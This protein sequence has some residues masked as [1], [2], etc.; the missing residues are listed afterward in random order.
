MFAVDKKRYEELQ[1]VIDSDKFVDYI[2]SKYYI[3]SKFLNLYED[4]NRPYEITSIDLCIVGEEKRG[5]NKYKLYFE[6][7]VPFAKLVELSRYDKEVVAKYMNYSEQAKERM[8]MLLN[9]RTSIWLNQYAFDEIL[10]FYQDKI[11][12]DLKMQLLGTDL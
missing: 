1:A 7:S 10:T 6:L 8:Q 9:I 12:H 2:K 3:R 11:V 5:R 4:R